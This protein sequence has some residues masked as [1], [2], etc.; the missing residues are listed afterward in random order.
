MAQARRN[1]DLRQSTLEERPL[2]VQWMSA[3]GLTAWPAPHSWRRRLLWPLLLGAHLALWLLPE[4]APGPQPV[5]AAPWLRLLTPKV[6]VSAPPAAPRAP[7]LPLPPAPA[8]IPPPALEIAAAQPAAP[9]TQAT[10][11]TT[12]SAAADS[13]PAHNAGSGTAPL[14]VRIP[15]AGKPG[16][17]TPF[18][19][20]ATN[21]PRSRSIRLT[22]EEKMAIAAGTAECFLEEREP[23][24]SIW[25]GPGKLKH[26]ASASALTGAAASAGGMVTVCVR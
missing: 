14:I 25:R 19:N 6:P 16:Q 1:I 5:P 21:D 22:F 12:P 18:Q 13:G 7:T 17:F 20:P 23:D 26:R 3:S 9:Q 8:L 24:G 2:G 15:S 4:R 11:S 10:P